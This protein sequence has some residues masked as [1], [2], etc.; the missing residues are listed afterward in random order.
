MK[1]LHRQSAAKAIE[2]L[3]QSVMMEGVNKKLIVKYADPK[4]GGKRDQKIN[5]LKIEAAMMRTKIGEHQDPD[6][7]I[8]SNGDEGD[9]LDD[10]DGDL[11]FDDHELIARYLLADDDDAS[12]DVNSV[13]DQ[14]DT[15]GFDVP[16]DLA[17]DAPSWIP[18]K[19]YT[20]KPQNGLHSPAAH[21]AYSAGV[22][23]YPSPAA[24][25]SPYPSGAGYGHEETP[26]YGGGYQ[27]HQ[28][29]VRTTD[30]KSIATSVQ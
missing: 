20:P 3:H 26:P 30:K 29:Q 6:G 11:D 4:R 25:Q 21:A 10:E 24:S 8:I 16:K 18:G 22:P 27:Q 7:D 15:L 2:T 28:H 17:D 23:P 5:A 1:F 9:G 12:A 13:V 14:F 19:P